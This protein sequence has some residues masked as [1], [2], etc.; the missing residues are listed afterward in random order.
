MLITPELFVLLQFYMHVHL[1]TMHMHAS[2]LDN[3]PSTPH[4]AAIFVFFC[5]IHVNDP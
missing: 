4:L 3:N 1:C 2:N 5:H